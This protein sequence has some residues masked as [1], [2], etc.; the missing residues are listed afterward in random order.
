MRVFAH[1]S[2]LL[3]G[4]VILMGVREMSMLAVT[5]LASYYGVILIHECGHM[6]AH[7]AKDVEVV[8]RCTQSG[9]SPD[10]IDPTPISTTASSHGVASLRKRSLRCLFYFGLRC[11]DTRD[12]KR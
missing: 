2:V 7:N 5:V 9:E 3:L 1:W 8:D 12:F 6:I 4:A 11:S 10:L